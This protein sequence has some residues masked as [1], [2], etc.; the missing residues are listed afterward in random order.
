MRTRPSK[1]GVLSVYAVYCRNDQALSETT[2]WTP[3]NG[4]SDPRVATLFKELMPVVFSDAP[5]LKPQRGG[6]SRP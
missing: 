4:P 2:A 1:P 3:A 5:E 6:A